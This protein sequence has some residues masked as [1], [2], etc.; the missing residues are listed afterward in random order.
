MES[1][2]SSQWSN[3]ERQMEPQPFVFSDVDF[4]GLNEQEM[5]DHLSNEIILDSL[6]D[7]QFQLVNPTEELDLSSKDALFFEFQIDN[8][9]SS[10][11]DMSHSSLTLSHVSSS[12]IN[13][14]KMYTHGSTIVNPVPSTDIST[15]TVPQQQQIQVVLQ[16][17]N[18]TYRTQSVPS[19]LFP[20]K[21]I[22]L[23][24]KFNGFASLP[25]SSNPSECP[26]SVRSSKT[27]SQLSDIH[28]WLVV[29]KITKRE[30][31]PYLYEFIQRLLDNP[32]YYHLATYIDKSVGIFKFHQP[33]E[34]AKLW[35]YIKGRNSGNTM[36]YD[37]LARAIRY[38]YSQDIIKPSSG[39]FTFRFGANSG[40][41]DK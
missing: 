20:N 34:V 32:S 37:K 18:S 38:Y 23:S 5:S 6:F 30:R 31:R 22:M 2:F 40:F 7:E 39:R 17:L 15:V 3:H 13:N 10:P 36:T 1:L 21:F 9:E 16:N 25:T 26:T 24:E 29:D 35:K 4:S 33:N 8:E 14:T 12:I 28:E 19:T 27:S 11:L 41:S